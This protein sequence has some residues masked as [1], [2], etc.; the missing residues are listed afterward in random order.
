MSLRGIDCVSDSPGAAWPRQDDALIWMARGY[1]MLCSLEFANSP[2]AL[3][4]RFRYPTPHSSWNSCTAW[5]GC[6]GSFSLQ[7]SSLH[8]PATTSTR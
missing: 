4:P 7:R 2:A 8:A 3:H 6:S 1:V 5:S